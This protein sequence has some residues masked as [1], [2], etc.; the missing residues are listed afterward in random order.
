MSI[1]SKAGLCDM[2][3]EASQQRI[4]RKGVRKGDSNY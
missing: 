3:D 4:C 1:G 2:S